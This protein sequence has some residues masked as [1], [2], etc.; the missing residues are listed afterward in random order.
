MI[1]EHLRSLPP[2]RRGPTEVAMALKAKGCRVTRNHV[3]VVKS[4]M[5]KTRVNGLA[6][7]LILAKRFLSAVGNPATAKRL[8]TLVGRIIRD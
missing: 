8:I 2:D 4:S 7:D 3:S 6:K 5:S 1:R